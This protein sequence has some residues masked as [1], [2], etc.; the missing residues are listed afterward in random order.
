MNLQYACKTL[1]IWDVVKARAEIWSMVDKPSA[2]SIADLKESAK[3]AFKRLAIGCHPD[4]GGDHNIYL[5]VK[6]AFDI[7]KAAEAKDFIDAL[8]FKETQY[9]NPGDD[10]CKRCNKWSDIASTCITRDC[11]G[12]EQLRQSTVVAASQ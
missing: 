4:T 2:T 7:V 11:T 9:F 6:E 1:G 3:V 8:Y 5:K 10:E 12:Y